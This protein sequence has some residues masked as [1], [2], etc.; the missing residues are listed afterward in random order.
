MI[1]PLL[2][3]VLLLKTCTIDLQ[4]LPDI[5][6]SDIDNFNNTYHFNTNQEIE[7][8]TIGDLKTQKFSLSNYGNDPIIDASFPLEIALFFYK[9]G[10]LVLLDN[11]MNI[12]ME[13]NL[14]EVNPMSVSHFGR[15]I[16]GMYWV[17]NQNTK[18][19]QKISPNGKLI[20][21]SNVL[22]NIKSLGI[23]RIYD[24]GREIYIQNGTE[25]ISFTPNLKY[26]NTE[27]NAYMVRSYKFPAKIVNGTLSFSFAKKTYNRSF[28]FDSIPIGI[29][30]NNY[31]L[32]TQNGLILQKIR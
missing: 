11:Q 22:P 19:L 8:Q 28:G 12:L 31:V 10:S 30:Q 7:K 1:K 18:T 5:H 13:N 6:R 29:S 14:Y 20:T 3:L 15:S 16:E 4:D 17:F 21:Q 9:N 32:Q 25:L 2:I 23:Q 27:K 24:L 26:V